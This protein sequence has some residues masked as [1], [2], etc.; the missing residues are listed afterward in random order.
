MKAA[1]IFIS[2]IAERNTSYTYMLTR[3]YGIKYSLFVLLA[4]V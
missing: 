2:S 3:S 4:V 1:A